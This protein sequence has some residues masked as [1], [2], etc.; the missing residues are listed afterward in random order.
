MTTSGA[1]VGVDVGG[2]FT[3]LV[4]LD[5]AAGTFRIAKVLSTPADQAVGVMEALGEVGAALERLDLFV[6]GT[7]VATNT[8]IERKGA[9]CG[10][11]TTRGFRDTLELRRR[12]RARMFGLYTEFQPLIP[13]WLRREVDERTDCDGQILRAVDEPEV[14]AEARRLLAQGVEAV[15]VVFLHSYA[16]PANERRAEQALRT[17]WPNEFISVSSDVLP[18]YREFERTSATVANSYLQP[19]MARYLRSLARRLAEAGA[20]RTPLIVQ[21][22]GSM[23][24][25]TTAA[26]RPIDAVLSGPAAGVVAAAR[27]G[28][29]CGF[30]NVISCDMGGTS[31][32]VC[33]VRAGR[34]TLTQQRTPIFGLPLRVPAVDIVTIGA[35]GGSIARTDTG[36]MLQVGPESA[37]ALPGP[38]CYGRGGTEPTVTDANLVLGRIGQR[39]LAGGDAALALD[40]D[41][42]AA[43]LE[44]RIGDVYGYGAEQAATAVLEVA[45]NNLANAIRSVSVD[46][47]H[48]PRELVLVVFGGAGP[49][50]ATALMRHLE[51]PRAIIP[52][53]PGLTSALGCVLAD[54][55]HDFVRTVNVLLADLDIEGARR[56]VAEHTEEGRALLDQTGAALRSVR[57]LVS[58]DASYDGQTHTLAVELPDGLVDREALRRLFDRRYHDE[59]GRLVDDT[60]VRVLNLRTAVVGE[61]TPVDLGILWQPPPATEQNPILDRLEVWF[62]REPT[63]CLAY[64]RDLLPLGRTVD[65]PALVVQSDTTTVLEPGSRAT[66]VEGGNLLLELG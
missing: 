34:P 31:F 62:G 20:T 42:A 46:R 38:V 37:G 5:P 14:V 43:S 22:N 32:D 23:M 55:R 16:N 18:E 40:R 25:A 51:V 44:Q 12:D 50:H 63:S 57:T 35:G 66:V 47:G 53:Y 64:Q 65:G 13:R 9:T 3:D 10:L 54:V 27:I 26:R 36:G 6:H 33:L 28:R 61:R 21:G 39:R 15:S 1:L 59:Y 49:L 4:Y 19:V 60:P 2:T 58:M 8:L 24:A 52:R 7:T 30:E 29:A 45:T 56:I 11:L 17:V 48:D 41:G